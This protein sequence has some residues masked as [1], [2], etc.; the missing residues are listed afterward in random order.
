MTSCQRFE[1]E[2][3]PRF[4]AGEALEG[5]FESCAD[6][7]TARARYQSLVRALELAR[8]AYP[9]RGDWQARVWADIARSPASSRA[10][11]PR[12][13]PWLGWAAGAA[14]AAALALVAF[15]SVGGPASLEVSTRLEVGGGPV[16]R[17]A[18][19][20]GSEVQYAVPGTVLHLVAKVPRGKL[21]DVRVYRGNDTLVFQCASSKAC[22]RSRDGLEARV[23][24][25]RAGSYRT[26]TLA[27]DALPAATGNLDADYAAA[28]RAGSALESAPIEV[29]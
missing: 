9:P 22:Q 16:V 23:T 19:S 10:A 14:A 26:L 24:L 1:S 25:D 7:R 4:V 21:G 3:L 18:S 20:V 17:G 15:Q 27:A 28:R 29:F 12:W 11:R 13:A 5:H 6:C 2:G 8:N